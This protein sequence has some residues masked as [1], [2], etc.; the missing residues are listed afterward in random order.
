MKID[1][2]GLLLASLNNQHLIEKALCGDVVSELCGLQAQF[3][4]NPKHALRVRGSDFSETTWEEGLVK[5]WSFRKTLH[6]VRQ[7]ET[8]LFLS[9]RG[10]PDNWHSGWN[11]ES[12]RMEYWSKFL[13]EK[14]ESGV[15]GRDALKEECRKKGMSQEEERNV[16]HGWGGLI[17]EMNRRGMIA[18]VPGTA[19]NFVLCR[20]VEWMDKDK[21]RALLL[22]RYFT[23]FGP[24][25]M[26]DCAYFTGWKKREILDDVEKH[27]VQLNSILCENRE[28]FFAEGLPDSGEI[29]GCIFLAGFDQL[30]MGYRDRSRVMDERHKRYVTTN[31]GIVH[32]TVLLDGRIQAK[33]KKN[34]VK[35]TVTPFCKIS[36]KN[37][38]RIAQYGKELFCGEPC[39]VDFQ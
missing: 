19:K 22:R 39:E 7:S 27:D 18:Y 33:W 9:A 11:L 21:A 35:L 1:L 16:F 5:I 8:G 36:Q 17:Y 37:R 23:A 25:T 28:Y 10:V 31:T 2:R 26:D 38:K 12:G 4:N 32:P 20:S 30:L 29:P 34:G 24:A 3:A 15:S 6:T 14:I 13:L